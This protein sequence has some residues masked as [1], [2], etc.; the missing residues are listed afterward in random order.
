[1]NSAVAYVRVSSRAQDHATQRS[2]IERAATARGDAIVDWRAEKRTAKT[3]ARAELQRLLVDSRAGRM[4]GRRL[5]VFR[6]DRLTRTGIADTLVTLDELR[7]N[8]VE[9]V[10]VADGFDLNGPH[11]EVVIAVMAW[12]AK[13]ERSRQPS[14]SPR[15]VI[16][17]RPRRPLGTTASSRPWDVARALAM[18]T[19]GHGVRAIARAMHIPRSTIARA[20]ASGAASRKHGVVETPI[21]R[22]IGGCSRGWT[23][24]VLAGRRPY[25]AA[26]ALGS[27]WTFLAEINGATRLSQP[28]QGQVLRVPPHQTVH[29]AARWQ[30]ES[31]TQV[32]S[33][34]EP[35]L[36]LARAN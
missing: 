35:P 22:A 2:A 17:L 1:M 10:S 32:G 29:V 12:A 21:N 14:G 16:A 31:R 25:W 28:L 34:A 8:G 24:S 13:I 3:M 7:A 9:I 36:V 27:V 5:Y 4:R 30:F 33:E 11:A 19:E 6:L 20:L 23:S 15:R 26:V 18:R